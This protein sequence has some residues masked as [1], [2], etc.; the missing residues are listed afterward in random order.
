MRSVENN[1]MLSLI[2][3]LTSRINK[4]ATSYTAVPQGVKEHEGEF[5]HLSSSSGR[6]KPPLPHTSSLRG[7]GEALP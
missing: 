3:T 4:I 2:R 6:A 7:K 1:I 5:D